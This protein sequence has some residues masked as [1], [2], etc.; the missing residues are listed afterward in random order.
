MI[1]LFAVA[2]TLAPTEL[3]SL[4][5]GVIIP[6][7][8]ALL[9]KSG[10]PAWVKVVVNLFLA[11]VVGGISGALNGGTLTVAHWQAIAISI[12]LTWIMSV[13]SYFGLY[14][15]TGAAQKISAKT[16]AIGFGPADPK[17]V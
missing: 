15:K 6:A 10:A 11:A 9:T 14:Q 1:H 17:P 7:L 3:W 2:P 16:A 8:T 13:A 5:L 12:A 4:L